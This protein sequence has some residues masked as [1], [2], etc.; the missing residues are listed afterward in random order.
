MLKGDELYLTTTTN[1][2]DESFDKDCMVSNTYMIHG[3]SEVSKILYQ[4]EDN[5]VIEAD[6]CVYEGRVF[7]KGDAFVGENGEVVVCD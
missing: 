2:L 5:R 6:I 3:L 1:L 4:S 7:N